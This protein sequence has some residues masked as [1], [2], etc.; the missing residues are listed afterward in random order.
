MIHFITYG[1]LKFEK[2]KHR[3]KLEASNTGLIQLLL[4]VRKI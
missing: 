4:M 3:I 2:S 1:D